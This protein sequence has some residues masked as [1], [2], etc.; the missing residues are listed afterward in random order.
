MSS[1]H[2]VTGA[3]ATQPSSAPDA[4]EGGA[5][6]LLPRSAAD[7]PAQLA[8]GLAMI[9]AMLSKQQQQQ[10]EQGKLSIEGAAKLRNAQIDATKAALQKAADARKDPLGWFGDVLKV[11]VGAV[12]TVATVGAAAPVTV[13]LSWAGF[14]G[15]ETGLFKDA[16]FVGDFMQAGAAWMSGEPMLLLG[17][18][19]EGTG[20]AIATAHDKDAQDVAMVFQITGGAVKSAAVFGMLA[21]GEKVQE[22]LHI[23]DDGC[24]TIAGGIQRSNLLY[25]QADEKAARH[26]AA[27]L[28]RMIESLIDGVRDVHESHDKSVKTLVGAMQT[29]DETAVIAATAT[30]A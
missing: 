27:R 25:A 16:G 11:V 7:D 8:D 23:V 5:P 30:R 24:R 13:G 17:H 9:Y 3:T 12:A 15:K 6:A 18:A 1:V 28:E 22:G 14:I 26:E 29:R 4:L 2:G 19:F 21:D 20:G 10:A